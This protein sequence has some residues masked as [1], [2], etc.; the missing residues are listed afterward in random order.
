MS[1]RCVYCDQSVLPKS[2]GCC[3]I[4]GCVL[5]DF[6]FPE[7]R[8]THI[9]GLAEGDRDAI[10]WLYQAY[11]PVLIALLKARY[12]RRQEELAKEIIHDFYF[13]K[14][15]NGTKQGERSRFATSWRK[16]KGKF[17]SFLWASL[18]YFVIDWMRRNREHLDVDETDVA[19][20][21]SQREHVAWLQLILES[22]WDTF[23]ENEDPKYVEI[24]RLAD[25]APLINGTP[26]PS[27]E[28]LANLCE[29]ASAGSA[30]GRLRTA[31]KRFK[32]VLAGS[33]REHSG[34]DQEDDLSEPIGEIHRLLDDREIL[35]ELT[36]QLQIDYGSSTNTPQSSRQVVVS[37]FESL[38]VDFDEERQIQ[39]HELLEQDLI[40]WRIDPKHPKAASSPASKGSYR[41]LGDLFH[42]N[43]TETIALDDLKQVKDELRSRLHEAN[44]IEHQN[45][46]VVYCGLIALALVYH[47]DRGRQFLTS[48]SD[49]DLKANFSNILERGQIPVRFQSLFEK[50]H[51]AID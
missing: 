5:V 4:C 50:A 36:N 12:F 3:P 16:E 40:K 14:V 19:V 29:L 37:S 17:R 35:N 10:A 1:A 28:E 31:R 43:G 47:G 25:V 15:I 8:L 48:L 32:T 24:H 13:K 23:R 2:D 49:S 39:L 18:R 51:A 42:Q 6:A 38:S 46:E 30:T 33:V 20:R 44:G 11:T 41:T 7:T 45:L 26:A 22:A 9:E 21:S 27:M 34:Y